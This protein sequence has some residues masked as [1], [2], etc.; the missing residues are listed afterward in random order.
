MGA[1]EGEEHDVA[2]GAGA[3]ED[4]G[5]AIDADAFAGGGGKAVAEGADVVVVDSAMASASPRLRSS[6]W[7]SKRRSWSSGSLSSEKALP[8]SK[9]PM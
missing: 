4:H 8:S 6:S 3:G 9:P 5:E 7:A 1:H 2:D